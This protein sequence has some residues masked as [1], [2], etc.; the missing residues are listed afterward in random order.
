MRTFPKDSFG[1]GGEAARYCIIN[2]DRKWLYILLL[3]VFNDEEQG[4]GKPAIFKERRTKCPSCSVQGRIIHKQGKRQCIFW[5]CLSNQLEAIMLAE[6]F[7]PKHQ[8]PPSFL[9]CV[10]IPLWANSCSMHETVPQIALVLSVTISCLC[11]GLAERGTT[12]HNTREAAIAPK[13]GCKKRK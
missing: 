6:V 9:R 2:Y 13:C 12:S 5:I 1:E 10:S 7:W 8:S 4:I 3:S 11:E